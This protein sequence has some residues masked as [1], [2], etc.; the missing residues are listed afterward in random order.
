MQEVLRRVHLDASSVYAEKIRPPFDQKMANSVLKRFKHNG[1]HLSWGVFNDALVTGWPERVTRC[2]AAFHAISVGNHSAKMGR[3][4]GV[5]AR[6][7]A[8]VGGTLP[9]QRECSAPEQGSCTSNEPG[10]RDV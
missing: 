3:I 5:I 4:D 6:K 2:T 10:G 1:T 8:L 7:R 9:V